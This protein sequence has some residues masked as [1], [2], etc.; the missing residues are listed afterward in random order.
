[1]AGRDGCHLRKSKA[2]IKNIYIYIYCMALKLV[3][4]I[5]N[6]FSFSF[7]PKPGKIPIFRTFQQNL[8]TAMSVTSLCCHTW[9]AGTYFGMYRKRRPM[10][11]YQFDV[12][13]G[14]HFQGHMG[15]VI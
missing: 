11:W 4:C 6:A 14:F 10:L 3:V 15:L 7:K 12:S 13:M 5:R 2:A 1:M 8:R 9:D